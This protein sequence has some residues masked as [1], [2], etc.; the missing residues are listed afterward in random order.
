MGPFFIIITIFST[1][2]LAIENGEP[3]ALSLATL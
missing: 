3:G 2:C 1:M